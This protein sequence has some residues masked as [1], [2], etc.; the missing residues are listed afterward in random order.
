MSR[1]VRLAAVFDA[2]NR[3]DGA[4]AHRNCGPHGAN[5]RLAVVALIA[6]LNS[7]SANDHRAAAGVTRRA[8]QRNGPNTCRGQPEVQVKRDK[9]TLC[10]FAWLPQA[11][12]WKEKWA[13]ARDASPKWGRRTTQTLTTYRGSYDRCKKQI[14]SAEANA[15]CV[16]ARSVIGTALVLRCRWPAPPRRCASAGGG[17][18]HG[19]GRALN[20]QLLLKIPIFARFF[21]S[22]TAAVPRTN[23]RDLETNSHQSGASL[24]I[25]RCGW[26]A[27]PYSGFD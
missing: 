18:G 22:Q 13:D 15:A 10:R 1:G 27:M 2:G 14:G 23:W 4:L 7:E 25:G 20:L 9:Q 3:L 5:S 12:S 17:S 19:D 21:S 16:M 11:A 8:P 6:R 26:K 24:W